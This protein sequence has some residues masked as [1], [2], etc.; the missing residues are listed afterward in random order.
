MKKR[1]YFLGLLAALLAL[2]AAAFGKAACTSPNLPLPEFQA[3]YEL[4]WGPLYVGKTALSLTRQRDGG[5][6]YQS[7]THPAGVV[8]LI[9]KDLITE[10]SHFDWNCGEVRARSY[11]ERK[12]D[13]TRERRQTIRFDWRQRRAFID[14]EGRKSSLALPRGT[15]DP[16][17]AQL[18]LS[19]LRSAADRAPTFPVLNNGKLEQYRFKDAGTATLDTPQGPL[20]TVILK[21]PD[22]HTGRT[23]VFW[24]APQLHYLPVRMQQV[25]P[26]KATISLKL[27]EIKFDATLK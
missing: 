2:P 4:E 17:L 1:P 18:A 15:L 10:T 24:L 19:L 9:R 3:R 11:A 12:D 6:V 27:T 26:G 21:R 8:A 14:D 22:P 16:L 23:L 7:V 5:Y 13:G 20:A 25:E